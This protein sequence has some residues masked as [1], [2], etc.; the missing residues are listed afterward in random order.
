MKNIRDF[1]KIL[2]VF[3]QFLNNQLSDCCCGVTVAQC[4]CLLAIED[5]GQTTIGDLAKYLF[6]DKSTLSRTVE[7][8]VQLGFVIREN[9]LEDRRINLIALSSSGLQQVE[10]M[11]KVNDHYYS[12]VF[13]N[14]P[15]IDR[16]PVVKYLTLFVKAIKQFESQRVNEDICCDERSL[17]D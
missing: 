11:H 2:R 10:K 14:I 15:V 7:S 16:E 9:N 6:L 5:L 4:H 13:E 3:E 8:L 17:N 12:Q 1:R